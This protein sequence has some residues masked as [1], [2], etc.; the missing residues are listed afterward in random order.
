MV[1][2]PLWKGRNVTSQMNNGVVIAVIAAVLV[3]AGF[4]MYQAAQPSRG[5]DGKTPA[6][7]HLPAAYLRN[8]PEAAQFQSR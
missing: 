5:G 2:T 8:H 6:N 7:V 1:L 4:F 3:I